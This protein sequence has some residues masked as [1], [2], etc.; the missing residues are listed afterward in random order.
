MANLPNSI[1]LK[2]RIPEIPQI[3]AICETQSNSFKMSFLTLGGIL[4]SEVTN[5]KYVW[6]T[7]LPRDPSI[8]G[9]PLSSFSI[10]HSNVN[11]KHR[12]FVFN[13]LF[14][15]RWIQHTRFVWVLL[16]RPFDNNGN[17]L[18]NTT[19]CIMCT[20]CII[21]KMCTMPFSEQWA[22]DMGFLWLRNWIFNFN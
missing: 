14:L 10:C 22:L 13:F 7:S 11:Y 15:S 2:G 12:V 21:I 18:W 16:H 6:P 3:H 19:D 9:G 4:N 1:N 17:T 20:E 5:T 8:F